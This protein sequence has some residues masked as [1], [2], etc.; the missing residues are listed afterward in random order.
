MKT[1]FVFTLVLFG[2]LGCA[3]TPQSALGFRLPDGDAAKGEMNF[4]A[5]GCK[6]CHSLASAS[7]Q[8]VEQD[9]VV[10]GGEVTR[11]KTYGDLVTSIINPS[12]RVGPKTPASM[13]MDDGVSLMEVAMLNDRLT[14][15][16]LIDLVAFLQAQY[17]VVPPNVEPYVYF[18]K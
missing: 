3:P 15:T 18:Y 9:R 11:V 7:A 12:H 2:V 13:R 10:L 6:S 4:H 16:E 5:I 17:E 1:V 8:P 14:I